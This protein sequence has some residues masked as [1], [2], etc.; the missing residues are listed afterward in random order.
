MDLSKILNILFRYLWLF[1]LTILVASLTTFFVLNKQPV[2]YKATTQLLVGP[3][4]DSPSPDLN[5]LKIGGQLVQTYAELVGTHSFLESVNDKLDHKIDLATLD[6]IISARQNTETRVLS[7]IVY[8]PDPK[9]AAAIANAAAQT[10]IDMSPSKDNTTALLRNQMSAQSHQLEQIVSK[11]ET[12]IEQLE[13]E[14]TNLKKTKLL[15]P[16][17]SQANLDQQNLVIRQLSDERSRMSDALRT[18]ATVYEVMLDTNTNQLQLIQAADVVV[19][20]DQNLSVRVITS[21][22]SGLVLAL[23]II[24]AVEFLDDRIRFAGDFTRMPGIALLS[25]I[26]KHPRLEGS[27]SERLITFGQPNSQAANNYR[28]VVARLL[29]SMSENTPHALLL[30]SVGSQS[31]NDTA[32][33]AGNLAVAFAR[34]GQRVALIDAQFNNPVLTKMFKA[35]NREGLVDAITT[36]PATPNLVSID[37]VP[38][39]RFLSAGL[40]VEKGPDVL[41]HSTKIATL[42]DAIAKEADIVL[43]AGSAIPWSAESLTLASQ[44]NEVILVA[45]RGEVHSRVFNRVVDNLHLMNIQIAGV[46]FDDNISIFGV[47]EDNQ[48]ASGLARIFSKI[49]V[50]KNLRMPGKMEKNSIAEQTTKS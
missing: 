42:V 50:L 49:A 46:I 18:L 11:A 38:G 45:R 20:V 48:E 43:V 35:G 22:V 31:G 25:T 21:A 10:L 39:V 2:S 14:L 32:I 19:P 4:L 5:A 28:E 7:I 23:I 16:E 34:T 47:D 24:F 15:S 27:G 1:V 29:F 8:H 40:S 33:V 37:E 44:V 26:N 6:R 12:N 30:S 36:D 17:A 3:G 41:L 13:I 9:Q